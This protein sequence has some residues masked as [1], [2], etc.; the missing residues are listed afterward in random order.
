MPA[1]PHAPSEKFDVAQTWKG[2][3]IL[4]DRGLRAP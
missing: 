2:T 4:M 3:R 1:H